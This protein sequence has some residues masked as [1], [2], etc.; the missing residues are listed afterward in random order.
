[1]HT[2]AF[3]AVDMR[4]FWIPFAKKRNSHTNISRRVWLGF[5]LGNSAEGFDGAQLK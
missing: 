3:H 5:S 4:F 1:V 2:F